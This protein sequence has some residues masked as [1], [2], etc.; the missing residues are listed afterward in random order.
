M[1]V[2]QPGSSPDEDDKLEQ[3]LKDLTDDSNVVEEQRNAANEDMR[4]IH[5]EGGMWE[6]FLVGTSFDDSDGPDRVKLEFDLVSNYVQ[7][8]LGEWDQNRVAVEYKP[9]D[10]KTSEEDAEVLNGIYRADQR[11]FSG[12]VATDNAVDEAATCGYGAMKLA[13]LFEDEGDP[14][15]DNQ[16]IEWRPITNAYNSVVWDLEAQRIDKRDATR[17]NE[18]V[19]FT[20]DSF[21]KKWPNNQPVSAIDPSTMLNTRGS[22]NSPDF[23]FVATRYEIVRKKET[24][25]IYNNLKTSKVEVYSKQD[26]EKIEDEL[27]KDDT[28]KFVRERKITKQFVEKTIF[29]GDAILESTRRIVGEWLPIIPF[30]GYRSYVD[31]TEWYRGLVRKLKDAARLFNMQVS[32]LA[33]NAASSGQEV[34]IFAPEQMKNV[35]IKDQWADKNNVPYLLADPV[36]NDAGDIIAAGPTGYTKPAQLDGSTAALMAIVPQFVSDATGGAPQDTLNTDMS[37]KAIRALIKRENMTTAIVTRN[38]ARAVE[39]SGVVYQS[40]AAEVYTTPRI[41]RTI[42]KD[43]R[44][45]QVQLNES[46]FDKE[47]GKFIEANTLTGKKFRSY[48]DVGPQYETLREQT[49]EDMKGML[50]VMAT[51]P[52]GEQYIPIMLAIMMD[53]ISGVGLDPIKEFNRRIMLQQGIVKPETPEEEQMLQQLQEQAQQPDAQQELL[54][55][56]AEQQ[57][58][59]ARSLDSSSVQKLADAKKK[60]AEV[61]QIFSGLTLDEQQFALDAQKQLTEQRAAAIDSLRDLPVEG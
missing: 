34:P 42:G 36:R 37:G 24:V 29:S 57:K 31:G 1:T 21:L 61:I 30:Y 45:G 43:G 46:V 54:T 47:S 13:T 8:F 17:V 39:W 28:R 9:D 11:T 10:S 22:W 32:Q 18:L 38:I 53:N 16:R 5:T 58:A 51:M 23:I 60:E 48:S 25:F 3:F 35:H 27:R 50:E 40:M 2:N 44:D 7:R 12:D 56:A 6:D 4:F 33:E 59:E 49:V 41:L 19:A 52:S 14:E 55:A 20:H 15:N 26:H